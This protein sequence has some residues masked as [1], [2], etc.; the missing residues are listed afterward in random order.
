MVT[1]YHRKEELIGKEVIEAD[2]KKVGTIKDMA[3]TMA[4]KLA[5]VLD[6]VSEKGESK[7]AYL[8]FDKIVKIG[9]VILIK[10]KD[11]L[12]LIPVKE[13]VCPNCK[14]RN[15]T[16]AKFCYKCGVTLA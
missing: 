6:I 3:F 12:E 14:S 7:M 15:P 13:K 8:S 11:D 4:G 1:E 5:L 9:D 16:D 2:A 10:S